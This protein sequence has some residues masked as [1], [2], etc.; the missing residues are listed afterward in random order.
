[1][2][3]LFTR[4]SFDSLSGD[5]PNLETKSPLS[6]VF[7]SLAWTKVWWQQFGS[8]FKLYLGSVKKQSKTIGIAPLMIKENNAYFIGN[9]NVCDYLD[10]IVEPGEEHDFFKALL[11][12]LTQAGIARLEL[13]PLRQDSVTLTNL[14]KIA[15]ERKIPA[16]MNKVDVSLDLSLPPTWEAYLELL[17]AKQRHELKRKMRRLSEMGNINFRVSLDANNKDIALFLKLFQDSREDKAAFLTPAM[18][19]FFQSLF[20][21]M[22]EEKLLRINVLESNAKPIAATV[23]LDY[24]DIVYLYNSG[25]EPEYRWLS[26]GLISKAMCI[27]ESIAR[28]KKCFDFLKGN[29]E[30]KYHLGGNE[31]PI[32]RYIMPLTTS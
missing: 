30:Y 7:S 32:Y 24:K 29:E 8:G 11:Q 6:H 20:K 22:A 2:D 21:T 4:E 10:F 23:C 9:I 16:V 3:A 27:Q 26:A 31:I 28:N 25:Y 14:S 1:M 13:E 12:N 17:N 15:E 5:W 18:E 19:S